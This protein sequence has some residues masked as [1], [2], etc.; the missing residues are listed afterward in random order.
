MTFEQ[1]NDLQVNHCW[2]TSVFRMR[3][4]LAHK[5][6]LEV[7]EL[8]QALLPH[9][10]P[11]KSSHQK[12]I[13]LKKKHSIERD[14][15]IYTYISWGISWDVLWNIMDA[16]WMHYGCSFVDPP[17]KCHSM[18]RHASPSRPKEWKSKAWNLQHSGPW[19]SFFYCKRFCWL[20]FLV[21]GCFRA[22][23][24]ISEQKHFIWTLFAAFRSKY[25]SVATHSASWST[26]IYFAPCYLHHVWLCAGI[27]TILELRSA[28]LCNLNLLQH[29]CSL[30]QSLVL[31]WVQAQSSM[32][33]LN[34]LKSTRYMHHFRAKQCY[35]M[36]TCNI[37]ELEI[38]NA[39]GI[40][41]IV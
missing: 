26:H 29:I 6:T 4:R 40:C 39:H 41:S 11:M 15:Y 32:F 12:S 36:G 27:C 1:K 23:C 10:S 16:L 9:G 30:G 24:R 13:G 20:S 5:V 22:I 25:I 38:C 2:W 19:I 14:I 3:M 37:L 34:Y 33:K 18:I 28:A 17:P 35:L 31:Y 8:C 21:W 7:L